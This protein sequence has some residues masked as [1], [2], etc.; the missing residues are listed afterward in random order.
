MLIPSGVVNHR[1]GEDS[2]DPVYF[3]MSMLRVSRVDSACELL[4][5]SRVLQQSHDPQANPREAEQACGPDSVQSLPHVGVGSGGRCLDRSLIPHAPSALKSSRRT[6]QCPSFP[7]TTVSIT[8]ALPR[9]WGIRA[10]AALYARSV[11][12]GEWMWWE[13]S[14]RNEE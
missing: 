5:P 10:C 3:S 7:A 11:P 14:I 1:L 9:G 6:T 2:D 12:T 8:S 13:A 4:L